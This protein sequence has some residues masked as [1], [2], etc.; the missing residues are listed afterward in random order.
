MVALRQWEPVPTAFLFNDMLPQNLRSLTLDDNLSANA[1]LTQRLARQI[2]SHG[3]FRASGCM[4]AWQQLLGQGSRDGGQDLLRKDQIMHQSPMPR[5]DILVHLPA[6][7]AFALG[8]CRNPDRADDLVQDTIV[9]AW[10]HIGSLTPATNF[11]GWLI[12]ILRNGYYSDLRKQR[13]EVAD[14]DGLFAA[15]LAVGPAH[16]SALALR[17][18]LRAFANLS[19]EHREV[20]TLVGALGL[21]YAETAE[22]TTLALGTVKSRV[23][24]ARALLGENPLPAV[25]NVTIGVLSPAAAY[26]M[27]QA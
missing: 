14:P 20:L 9:K 10:S 17:E 8:L 23:S 21:S 18:F 12:T 5:D 1:F 24:R 13:R 7:R 2:V 3:V 26:V 6:L 16:D 4:V 22:V 27:E 11:L 25:D 19:S 15:R